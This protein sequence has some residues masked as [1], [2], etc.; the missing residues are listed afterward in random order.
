MKRGDLVKRL[1]Q[2]AKAK[3][4]ELET[5]REGANHTLYRIGSKQ[6]P[7]PRHREINEMTAQGIL[8]QAEEG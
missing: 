4:L 7:V 2:T 8:K 1:R 6:F 3:G 5:V